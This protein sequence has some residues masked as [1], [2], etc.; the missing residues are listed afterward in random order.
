MKKVLHS[1]MK[2]TKE[3]DARH[4]SNLQG[5]SLPNKPSL[6]EIEIDDI[7]GKKL[8]CMMRLVG[9][10][11]VQCSGKLNPKTNKK[12]NSSDYQALFRFQKTCANEETKKPPRPLQKK[13]INI[14]STPTAARMMPA[15]NMSS[16]EVT[17]ITTTNG[18]GESPSGT[19]LIS[20]L[21]ASSKTTSSTFLSPLHSSNANE[22]YPSSCSEQHQLSAG[23]IYNN[24][25]MQGS[26]EKSPSLASFK[27]NND[28]SQ[29]SL[30]SFSHVVDGGIVKRNT[31]ALAMSKRM[32]EQQYRETKKLAIKVG[33]LIY[34]EKK[35]KGFSLAKFKS[36]NCVADEVDKLFGIKSVVSGNEILS[37][38][39]NNEVAKSPKRRGPQ[40][41]IPDEHF[42]IICDLVWTKAA[43]DQANASPDRKNRKEMESLVGHLVNSK[44]QC[45]GL[46][47]LNETSFYQ[48]VETR[49]APKVGIKVVGHREEL[50]FKW[51]T[52]QNM[53]A[54]HENWEKHMVDLG[55]AR[56][57]ESEEEKQCEGYIVYFEDALYR[58]MLF[59]EMPFS[60]DGSTNGIGGRIAMFPSYG[61]VNESGKAAYK[62]DTKATF[63]FGMTAACEALP[64]FLIVK[65]K[66]K[67]PK[68]KSEM[69]I[70][71]H[72]VE[73]KFGWPRRMKFNSMIAASPS[74][75]MNASLFASCMETYRSQLYPTAQDIPG[76]R[77]IAKSDMGPGRS[78]WNKF[79]IPQRNS[80]LVFYPGLPNGTELDQEMDQSYSKTKTCM[81]KNRVF[82]EKSRRAC[83]NRVPGYTCKLS[84]V[85]LPKILFG[86]EVILPDGSTIEL[87]NAFEKS[88]ASDHIRAALS[89]CGYFPATRQAFAAKKL[90]RHWVDDNSD[91]DGPGCDMDMAYN[92]IMTDI[93]NLNRASIDKLEQLG[94]TE[95]KRFTCSLHTAPSLFSHFRP[96]TKSFPIADVSDDVL[97]KLLNI[98]SAGQWFHAT[99]GGGPLNCIEMLQVQHL[100]ANKI[101]AKKLQKRKGKIE[102]SAEKVAAAQTILETKPPSGWK[103]SDYKVL[104]LS[105]VPSAKV[106]SMKKK[107]LQ[108]LWDDL[109]DEPF[110]RSEWNDKYTDLLEKLQSNVIEPFDV[111]KADIYK[112]ANEQ[113]VERLR[114]T[115]GSLPIQ[116]VLKVVSGVYKKSSENNKA[117]LSEHFGKL[118]D[119]GGGD[120]DDDDSSLSIFS[121]T[122][123][124]ELDAFLIDNDEEEEKSPTTEGA[125]SDKNNDDN[126][127]NRGNGND[128]DYNSNNADDDND[129]SDNDD[130]DGDG[131]DS[132]DNDDANGDDDGDGDGDGNVDVD[133]DGD[134]NDDDDSK[135]DEKNDS[136]IS[137]D[138]NINKSKSK[139]DICK[140]NRNNSDV[141]LQ[142]PFSI[143]PAELDQI[144][145]LNIPSSG[146]QGEYCHP[147][148][149]IITVHQQVIIAL[150][151]NHF[152]N[153]STIDL[154]MQW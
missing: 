111:T 16:F 79:L 140:E 64:P 120:S 60:L 96:S 2:K 1:I 98:K 105:K 47:P 108:E 58:I 134:G 4:S 49:N 33:S 149:S 56:W 6:S 121:D 10:S 97:E 27:S 146:T 22:W 130:D 131:N 81:E 137:S 92:D 38:I 65:S 89:K 29:S 141:I 41:K 51:L 52:Y 44:L 50:R 112:K 9:F 133:G 109:K 90:R 3:R 39:K 114:L 129:N 99:G 25:R 104:I 147:Q 11:E 5:I 115:L 127:D 71:M 119:G 151:S 128:N 139:S 20:P 73:G 59:D 85:D 55:V 18:Q 107:E 70:N 144:S 145:D 87:D 57:P 100:K 93:Q 67:I 143:S 135:A 122:D 31:S 78:D 86:G 53:K 126:D 75:G 32:Q 153:D 124:A 94:Y 91:D 138:N 68:F 88:Y 40:S 17:D 8:A 46:A 76:E 30:T 74:G 82:L 66:A 125:Q 24:Q 37:A 43:L 23:D 116:R 61:E 123:I 103:V 113:E 132:N 80:G 21:S 106:T 62:T 42:K 13:D 84:E 152:L 102:N 150:E 14:V 26:A 148:R 101:K 136:N 117:I 54:Q 142:F 45:D 95:A 15:R 19:T 63:M 72:Q 36:V 118:A 110:A 48:R 34:N 83:E 7:H 69:I 28:R 35:E 12:S 154:F 77:V